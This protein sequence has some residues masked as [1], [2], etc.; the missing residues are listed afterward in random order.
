MKCGNFRSGF[1]VV[2]C[3]DMYHHY[4]FRFLSNL[5]HCIVLYILVFY[6]CIVYI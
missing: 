1:I 2:L 4:L 3:N 6:N 5:S